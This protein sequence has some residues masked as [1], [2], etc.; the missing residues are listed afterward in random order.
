MTK[1]ERIDNG[2]LV[3]APAVILRF[4]RC[5]GGIERLNTAGDPYYAVS[6]F[7]GKTWNGIFMSYLYR[8]ND[9]PY[10]VDIRTGMMGKRELFERAKG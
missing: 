9:W 2:E 5:G 7:N 10:V 6:G 4:L 1:M 8:W 3:K